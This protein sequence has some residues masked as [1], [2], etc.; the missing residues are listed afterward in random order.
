LFSW[1][2][3]S[4]YIFCV[5]ITVLIQDAKRIPHIILSSVGS[6]VVPVP[7]FSTLSLKWHD[8]REKKIIELKMYLDLTYKLLKK[9]LN[10]IRLQRDKV[11]N[12]RR[13]PCEVYLILIRFN[14]NLNFSINFSKNTQISNFMKIRPVGAE[15]FF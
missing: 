7:H 1:K 2:S 9:F 5:S 4:Y 6:K 8:F 13:Y 14:W 10:L 15:F 3:N 11:I 12:V